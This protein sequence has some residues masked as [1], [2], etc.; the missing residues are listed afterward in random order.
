MR[1]LLGSFLLGTLSLTASA[2]T[3]GVDP[4]L[5]GFPSSFHW[6]NVP[7]AWKIQDGILTIQPAGKTDWFS[8]PAGEMR[9]NSTPRMLA[10]APKEFWFSAK[11]TVDFK[12]LFDEGSLVVFADDDN[13]VKFSLKSLNNKTGLID[14]VVTRGLS[15]DNTGA[16]IEGNSV[17]LKVSKSG[18]GIFLFYST[19]G[20]DWKISRAFNLGPEKPLYI[21]F[22]SQSPIGNGTAAT[23]SEIRYQARAL[24]PWSA[25]E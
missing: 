2:Q 13:W 23:F 10:P 22:C 14:A 1:K 20:K 4:A 24:K 18:P 21:G 9:M 3:L 11:V 8:E 5:S 19:D 16:I 7:A 25:N 6:R 15:D 17:Y 12:T